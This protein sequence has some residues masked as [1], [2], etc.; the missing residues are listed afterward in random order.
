MSGVD[1]GPSIGRGHRQDGDSDGNH[2][3]TNGNPSRAGNKVRKLEHALEVCA[4]GVIANIATAASAGVAA[5]I[6]ATSPATLE[7]AGGPASAGSSAA[8]AT[9]DSDAGLSQQRNPLAHNRDVLRHIKL[10][11]SR[12]S[13][14]LFFAGVS[15]QWKAAWEDAPSNGG[16]NGDDDADGN[17]QNAP[18]TKQTTVGAALQSVSRLAWA[19]DCGCP[20]NKMTSMQAASGGNIIVLQWARDRGC[21]V[22]ENVCAAAAVAGHLEVLQWLRTVE[23]P[24]DEQVRVFRYQYGSVVSTGTPASFLLGWTGSKP[25]RDTT[26]KAGRVTPV[27]ERKRKRMCKHIHAA[28]ERRVESIG[29]RM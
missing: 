21:P 13:D 22:D 29:S 8:G 16:P 28:N 10:F 1:D 18:S 2:D 4:P 20:W 15:R 5:A 6:T 9:V 27:A 3:D 11:A 23:C 14:F 19:K 7:A 25:C 17:G 12:N 26:G 24:W